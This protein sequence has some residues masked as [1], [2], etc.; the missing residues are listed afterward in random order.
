MFVGLSPEPLKP[1]VTAVKTLSGLGLLINSPEIGE[2]VQ[3]AFVTDSDIRDQAGDCASGIRTAREAEAVNLVT[4][5]VIEH[6]EIVRFNNVS[7]QPLSE[8]TS[9]GISQG[10][11]CCADPGV[12]PDNLLPFIVVLIRADAVQRATQSSD[13]GRNILLA[14]DSGLPCTITAN[15]DALPNRSALGILSLPENIILPQELTGMRR[16]K[17]HVML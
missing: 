2:L 5:V 11:L 13:V 10:Q 9:D 14:R 4:R 17:S 12:I 15:D 3:I 8:G 6:A 1:L 7:F 16:M